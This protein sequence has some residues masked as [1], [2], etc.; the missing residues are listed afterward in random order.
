MGLLGL[1]GR[2]RHE[3]AGF[4]LYTE[5]VKAARDPFYYQVLDVPD[6]M[7]GRFDMI[8]L[9]TFLLIDRVH[10][11]EDGKALA[12]A[13]FDAMFLDMDHTLRE[14]GVGDIT[15]GRKNKAMWEALNGRRQA[16]EA[17]VAAGDVDG[18]ADAIGR[19]VWRGAPPAGVAHRLAT[20][21]LDQHRHL[22]G[23]SLESL[24]KGEV[25]FLAPVA[26]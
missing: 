7:D 2:K 20:I 23:Q 4:A 26:A 1:F 17:P 11:E 14:L 24:R 12:Q 19:N 16:Y 5:A 8:G 15:V 13:V 9:Y 18:L 21:V 3:R 10:R 22:A 6:S 25:D